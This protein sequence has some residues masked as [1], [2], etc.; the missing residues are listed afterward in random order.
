MRRVK[1]LLLYLCRALGL[2]ALARWWTRD[3]LKILCYHGFALRDEQHFRPKLFISAGLFEQRLATLARL[4]YRVLPL[5]QAVDDLYA[6]RTRKDTVAI[7]VDDGF[8]S[9]H[10]LAVPLLRR[11]GFPSTVYV[12][13]YYVAQA[14]PVFRLLL[15]YMFW[16]AVPRRIE[17]AGLDGVAIEGPVDLADAE[18][19]DRLLWACIDHGEQR[20]DEAQRRV[21]C[22]RLGALLQVDFADLARAHVMELMRPEQLADLAAAGVTVELHTHRH[23][24]PADETIARGEIADNRQ[25]LQGWLPGA[26]FAHF[27]Y[28]SGEWDARQWA[29]LDAMQ[30]R[31]STTC[32]PG[33]NDRNTPRHALRRFLDGEDVHQIEFEAAAS[34][35]VDLARRWLGHDRQPQPV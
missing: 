30:V 1:I 2:F 35:F 34:G 11:H 24:F 16:K 15:Q 25:A 28:P 5:G 27:C 9:F 8:R 12:T 31:S 14:N 17:V 6:G 7:T 20:C 29:W 26:S 22:E 23:R 4:G 10:A 21:L 19:A 13:S 3:C 32:E 18:A 33:L